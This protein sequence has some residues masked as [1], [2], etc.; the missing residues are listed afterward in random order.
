MLTSIL[1]F[2]KCQTPVLSNIFPED[3]HNIVTEFLSGNI[4]KAKELQLKYLPFIHS[5]FLEVNPIPVKAALNL[6][7][8]DFGIPRLPLTKISEENLN[9]LKKELKKL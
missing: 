3:T 4:T 5:L 2:Q 1:D 9:I 7:G 6:I 8:Y